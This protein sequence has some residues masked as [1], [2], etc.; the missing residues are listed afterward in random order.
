MTT[1]MS[2]IGEATGMKPEDKVI[3]LA[4]M[5]TAQ[6]KAQGYLAG[7]IAATSSDLRHL[8]L[9]HLQDELAG[10]ERAMNLAVKRGWLKPELPAEQWIKMAASDAEAIL[11]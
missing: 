10:H 9:T 4:L 11:K 3:G 6:L 7:V 1:V 5:A 2:A 8:L